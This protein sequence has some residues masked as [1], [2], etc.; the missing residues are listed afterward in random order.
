MMEVFYALL[1]MKI[2][3]TFILGVV[4]MGWRFIIERFTYSPRMV[5]SAHLGGYVHACYSWVSMEKIMFLGPF[6]LIH[7]KDWDRHFN[8][9]SDS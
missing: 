2:E 5:Y 9:R 7:A 1:K 3:A 8:L 4:C 6:Y